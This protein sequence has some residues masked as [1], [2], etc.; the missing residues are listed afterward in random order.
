VLPAGDFRDWDAIE[1]WALRIS[2]ELASTVPA[3]R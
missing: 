3:G 1:R 2:D